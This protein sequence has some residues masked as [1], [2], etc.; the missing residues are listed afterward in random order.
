[1]SGSVDGAAI[2]NTARLLGRAQQQSRFFA[3]CTVAC[4][5]QVDPS[6]SVCRRQI[7]R[8]IEDFQR[9]LRE[10]RIDHDIVSLA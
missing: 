4:A 10:R 2:E 9:P 1:V 7:E 6:V 8:R 3:E 5:L